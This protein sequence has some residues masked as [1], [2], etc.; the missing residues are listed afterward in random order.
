MIKSKFDIA[1]KVWGLLTAEQQREAI[2][3]LGLM[4]IGMIFETFGIA[5]VMP[6]LALMTQGDLAG[7]YPSLVPL[8]TSI[9][10]PSR[11]RLV[12]VGMLVLALVYVV[13]TVFLA[14]LAWRQMEYVYGVQKSLAQRLYAG[15]LR[16]PYV[17]HLQRN[18]AQL[19]NN[20]LIEVSMF[21]HTGLAAG[22]ALLMELLGLFGI[23]ALLLVVEPLGTL[24]VMATLGLVGWGY[25]HFT[26]DLVLRWGVARQH[27]EGLRLQQL[28]QGL[29]SVKDVKLLGREDDLL[30]QFRLHTVSS[31]RIGQL[32][33]TLQQLPR[34]GLELCAIIGLVALVM[35]MIGQGNSIEALLPAL[36]L[37][38]AAAFRVMPSVNRMLGGIQSLH[39]TWPVIE[40]LR[41][42]VCLLDNIPAMEQGQPMLF[43]A[44]LTLEEVTFRY[45]STAA[46]ALRGVN[47]SIEKGASIGFIGASG[48]GKSTLMDIILGLL[49]PESGTIKVDGVDIQTNLRGWQDQIGYVPQSIVLTDDTLRRNVAFGLLNEQID[50][51]AVWRAIRS[52]QLEPFINDLPKGLDTLVGERG[53]RLS[54][55]QRQRIGIA[56]ALYHDPAVL[57]L[58]EATSSL[59]AATERDFMDVV[60]ALQGTKTVLIVAHRLSTIA[61]C[62]YVFHFEQGCVIEAGEPGVV[63]AKVGKLVDAGDG[64]SNIST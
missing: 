17:F 36:G 50:E 42:E 24:V 34:L 26:R 12:I 63:L 27:H 52:A 2:V 19:I 6:A 37:F 25:S 31:A 9:G 62:D 51:A 39:Y 46:Q 14:F 15:Y 35:V 5:L 16:Q 56:R 48:S 59:D 58:D 22:L 18:S 33:S 32:Q 8:L 53:V 3:L 47:L 61:Q 41:R 20:I 23:T 57:V 11:E 21:T 4:L 54:G 43:K 29:G 30:S 64:C 28:Q 40:T 10:N 44:N 45:P 7:K 13:K 49:T 38:A 55:G 60:C 1:P